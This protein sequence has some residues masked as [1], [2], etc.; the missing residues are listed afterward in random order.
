MS[1]A[2]FFIIN[3]LANVLFS[4]LFGYLG[5]L[6]AAL[7]CSPHI[8]ILSRVFKDSSPVTEVSL[9]AY[10]HFCTALQCACHCGPHCLPSCLFHHCSPAPRKFFLG[11]WGVREGVFVIEFPSGSGNKLVFISVAFR[12]SFQDTSVICSREFKV[13]CLLEQLTKKLGSVSLPD[14]LGPQ[15]AILRL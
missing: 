6:H 15:Q 7:W 10:W 2:G 5:I 13:C 3:A 9:Q 8:Q 11:L 12:T 1:S 4:C 14:I